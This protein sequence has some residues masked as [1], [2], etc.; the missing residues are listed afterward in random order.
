MIGNQRH[1]LVVRVDVIDDGP[2]IP[3]ELRETI[4]YPMVT[5]RADG[6]GLGLSI[7]QTLIHR[8]N[9]FIDFESSPGQTTFTIW[10][11]LETRNA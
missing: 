4:F 6:T 1:K 10:L 8:H 3:E 11:P 7:A 2:G 5:G 9:G